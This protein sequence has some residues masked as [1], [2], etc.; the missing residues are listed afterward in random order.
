MIIKCPQCGRETELEHVERGR[1]VECMCGSRFFL[2]ELTVVQDYSAIDQAPPEKIGPYKIERFIG[3]GGMGRVYKGIHP[4]LGLPVAVKILL[5]EFANNAVFKARF[6]Q[7]AKICAKLNHP[8][9]VRV[10]DFG[11][12]DD[13]TLYLVMEYIAG[14]TLHDLLMRS[15]PLDPEKTARIA[16]AVCDG[17]EVAWSHGIVHRDI[18]PDNL[19]ITSEGEYKLS[20]LGLAKYEPGA[21]EK[22]SWRSDTLELS[23]LGTPDYMAPEQALNAANCDIRADIYSLGITL[24]QLLSGR[25]PFIASSREEVRRMHLEVEA[26]LPGYYRPG[27]PMDLE[28]I[29]MRCIQKR[30]TD[31]YQTPADL[32]ADL[33]AYLEGAPLPSTTSGPDPESAVPR[34]P[35]SPA[36]PG[37]ESKGGWRPTLILL[38]LL[39]CGAA[40]IF[41]KIAAFRTAESE[42]GG[43]PSAESGA[44]EES[45]RDD[46]ASRG[47]VRLDRDGVWADTLKFAQA[48]LRDR[49]DF[50]MA[51]LNL[52]SFENDADPKRRAEARELLKRLDTACREEIRERRIRL[53][54][55][56]QKLLDQEKYEEVLRLYDSGFAD[57]REESRGVREEIAENLTRKIEERNVRR[58]K[59][60]EFLEKKIVPLLAAG[61]YEAAEELYLSKDNPV[62]TGTK[63]LDLIRQCASVP[64]LFAEQMRSR[65]GQDCF[66]RFRSEPFASWGPGGMKILEVEPPEIYVQAEGRRM[67]TIRDLTWDEQAS[68]IEKLPGTTGEGR[69]LWLIG[70]CFREVPEEAMTLAKQLPAELRESYSRYLTDWNRKRTQELFRSELRNFLNEVGYTSKD[71]PEPDQLQQIRLFSALDWSDEETCS[72]LYDRLDL[73]IRRYI[74][75]PD[76]EPYVSALRHIRADV[77]EHIIDQPKIPARGSVQRTGE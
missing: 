12:T 54:R 68:E 49:S 5:P 60:A 64:R 6:I 67:F 37:K 70:A 14:G 66:F 62:R 52:K 58:A 11:T 32:H 45:K 33:R 25:L 23:S 1:H 34:M 9:I 71:V 29:V 22:A 27:I 74:G 7:S 50:A 47:R 77:E 75:L 18:K 38:A 39:L 3:R 4:S 76:L 44:G 31:R 65:T 15:G 46:S 42:N 19:M 43:N 55:Q 63:I 10:Y 72:G 28:Y 26:K 36:L 24:Y 61:E 17:L 56:A 59:A 2:D 21:G 13:G 40:V 16:E 51:I 53:D 30:R 35:A 8:N 69:T 73:L 20:D 57:L 41:A 48:A